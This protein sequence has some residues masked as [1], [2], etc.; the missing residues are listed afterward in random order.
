M[1]QLPVP[2]KVN[3][4]TKLKHAIVFPSVFDVPVGT[5]PTEYVIG[6]AKTVSAEGIGY[7]H[8]DINGITNWSLGKRTKPSNNKNGIIEIQETEWLYV[9]LRWLATTDTRFDVKVCELDEAQNPYYGQWAAGQESYLGCF[10]QPMSK[11]YNNEGDAPISKVPFTYTVFEWIKDSSRF[12]IGT[13]IFLAGAT[14][15]PPGTQV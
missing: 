3:W 7:N 8:E 10:V 11:S 2:G 4:N 5:A 15:V 13:G 12:T 9:F 6:V 14:P 1:S